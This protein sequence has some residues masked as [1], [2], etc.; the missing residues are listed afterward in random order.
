MIRLILLIDDE[1][2][3]VTKVTKGFCSVGWQLLKQGLDGAL[4]TVHQDEHG[5]HCDCGDH[6]WRRHACKHE[7]ALREVGL[8]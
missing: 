7:I 6:I 1:A 4:H 5:V 2:Y 3:G 8:L